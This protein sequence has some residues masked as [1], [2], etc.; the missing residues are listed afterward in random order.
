MKSLNIFCRGRKVRTDGALIKRSLVLSI[1]VGLQALLVQRA[2]GEN[3][4]DYRFDD[5]AEDGHRVHVQ[6][7]SAL[8]ELL[9][10]PSTTLQGEFVYDTISGASPTGGPPPKGSNRVPLSH[11]DI[12]DARTAGNLQA[13]IRWGGRQTT[14]PQISYSVEEDYES[15]GLSLNHTIDFN[16]KNTTLALG[17]AYTYDT[18]MPEF[19]GGDKD[20]KNSGDLLVGLTQLLGPKTIF[21]ANFTAGHSRGYLADPYKGFRFTGYPSA[22]S[23]FAE[24]RPDERTKEI[25]FLSLTHFV[26]PLKGSVELSYRLYH[27]SYDILSHT[28]SL[29]WF[30][31]IGK[32]VVLSP[33]FRFMDQSAADFYAVQ[34]PGDP[35]LPSNDPFYVP[36]PKVFSADYRLSALQTFTF[37]LSAMVKFTDK[38][39]LDLAYQRYRM[40]GTDGVTAS[41]A[42]PSANTFSAGFRVSF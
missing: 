13:A 5:Y 7:H 3:H 28:V 30:Q 2:R 12:E 38:I 35:L 24:V 20:Y 25:G 31:K 11:P 42:Y 16:D 19:W 32:H 27:D 18:I 29:S 4:F 14:T 37:G 9:V 41:S 26:T 15:V 6:T 40:V 33:M 8:L 22:G 1:A 17:F 34:L 10:H 36:T 39:A 23:L 21:T